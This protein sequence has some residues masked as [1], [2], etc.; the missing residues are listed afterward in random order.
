MA[1]RS[2]QA[3]SLASSA[4]KKRKNVDREEDEESEEGQTTVVHQQA[5]KSKVLILCSRGIT[6]RMRHLM[7]DLAN[8]ITHGKKGGFSLLLLLSV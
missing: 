5:Y 3:T 8:L 7:N 6:Y 2:A 1:S 4:N